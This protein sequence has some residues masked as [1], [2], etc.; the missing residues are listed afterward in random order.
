MT[1]DN[2]K[3][4]NIIDAV[5]ILAV[6]AVFASVFIRSGF[7]EKHSEKVEGGM[8]EYE[9]VINSLKQ[10][11]GKRFEVGD[12]FIMQGSELVVGE[13]TEVSVTDR[14]EGYIELPTGEIVRTEIPDRIDIKGKAKVKGTVDSNGR[15]LMNGTM[16]IAA[17]KN[18]YAH[19]D[20]ISFM[21]SIESV[22]FISD[23]NA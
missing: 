3:R 15:C 4:F 2:K 8:L 22:K 23:K 5:L 7:A 13:I 11:S 16:H 18:I 21:F 19:T 14:A 9:F 10:T 12:K 1:Q 6:L 17:G 20:D